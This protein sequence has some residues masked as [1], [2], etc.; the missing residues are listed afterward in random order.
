MTAIWDTL[1]PTIREEFVESLAD[2]VISSIRIFQEKEDRLVDH[3]LNI[4]IRTTAL[5]YLNSRL[6]AT[7]KTAPLLTVG[8]GE[9]AVRW[10]LKRDDMLR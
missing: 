6:G 8:E 5:F 10:I 3:V 9:D 7:G 1:K 2:A 4:L